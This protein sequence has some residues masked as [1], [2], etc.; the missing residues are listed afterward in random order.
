MDFGRGGVDVSGA[1]VSVAQSRYLAKDNAKS[2]AAD[3]ILA[4]PGSTGATGEYLRIWTESRK[5]VND[6][7]PNTVC[8]ISVNG[9]RAGAKPPPYDTIEHAARL[10][11]T[12]L[13]D[14]RSRRPEGGNPYNVGEQ[15]VADF[16]RGLG[17]KEF[18]GPH[19]DTC[20]WSR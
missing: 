14:G 18:P 8:F 1:R 11:C 2:L 5:R 17:F 20:H 10:G 7:E 13:T 6:P 9:S 15:K 16:L 4:T 19:P 12:F 3:C